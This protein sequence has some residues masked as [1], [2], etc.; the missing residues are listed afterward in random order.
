MMNVTLHIGLDLQ[1]IGD[2]A[3]MRDASRSIQP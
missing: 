1:V 2:Q 3:A